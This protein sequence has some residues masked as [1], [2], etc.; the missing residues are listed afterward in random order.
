MPLRLRHSRLI[1]NA[2]TRPPYWLHHLLAAHPRPPTAAGFSSHNAA[3]LSTT[4]RSPIVCDMEARREALG[5]EVERLRALA[6][7]QA[8]LFNRSER[9][10]N[11]AVVGGGRMGEIRCQKVARNQATQLVAFVDVDPITAAAFASEHASCEAY[12]ALEDAIRSQHIDAVWICAPTPSHSE[13]IDMA[14]QAGLHVAVEKPV[15]MTAAEIKTAYDACSAHGVHLLCAF[16]RRS[17]AAYEAVA[18]AVQD[19]KVGSLRSI[20]AV[21]RDHPAPHAAFFESGGGQLHSACFKTHLPW[22]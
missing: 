3:R 10:L 7:S 22:L 21:F 13:L 5:V 14:A 2:S 9:L 18:R 17:D 1:R 11:I 20:R 4:S 16:Q 8:Q 15:A 12:V 6:S 19:G